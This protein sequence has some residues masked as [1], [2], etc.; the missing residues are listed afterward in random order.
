MAEQQ[1]FNVSHITTAAAQGAQNANG[2]DAQTSGAETQ[3]NGETQA[4]PNTQGGLGRS[5]QQQSPTF[6]FKKATDG[7]FDSLESIM[8]AYQ[9]TVSRTQD[10]QTQLS[11]A[12]LQLQKRQHPNPLMAKL[13]DMYSEGKTNE[14]IWPYLK[15]QFTDYNSMKPMDLI[16]EKMRMSNAG[17]TDEDISALIQ[18][19]FGKEPT[20]A[21]FEGDNA[22]AEYKAAKAEYDVKVRAAAAEA[23]AEL[24]KSKLPSTNPEAEKERLANEKR[25]QAISNGYKAATEAVLGMGT[26]VSYKLE[27]DKVINGDYSF[28][29]KPELSEENNKLLIEM[30]AKEAQ[31]I[32]VPVFDPSAPQDQVFG[33]I[34]EIKETFLWAIPKFREEFLKHMIY[35]AAASFRQQNVQGKVFN[36]SLSRGSDRTQRR[37]RPSG[38]SR[39]PTVDRNSRMV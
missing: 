34:N 35:D 1:E 19:D 9:N 13:H 26:N 8:G 11:N 17:F 6:D 30:V 12:Q 33:Q 14:E 32:G 27:Q 38:N 15:Q 39:F 31:R 37:Q 16:Q 36:K 4:Q 25:S 10:L 18:R 22:A 7:K 23:K 5:Q 28:D 29:Y 3:G 20:Q 21:D 24:L 2:G